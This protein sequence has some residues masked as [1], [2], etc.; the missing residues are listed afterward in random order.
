MPLIVV[1]LL[2]TLILMLAQSKLKKIT[3]VTDAKRENVRYHTLYMHLHR[4]LQLKLATSIFE[5]GALLYAQ[6]MPIIFRI[7]TVH[8]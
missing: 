5:H 2:L 1:S 6:L 3:G 8:I 4:N 7:S